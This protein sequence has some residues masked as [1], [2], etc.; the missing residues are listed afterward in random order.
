MV[1]AVASDQ[2]VQEKC[3]KQLAQT[4]S[5]KLKYLSYHPVTG[6]YTA[7]NATRSID[8]LDIRSVA[9]RFLIL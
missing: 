5:R 3:T 4:V 2:V 8:Q 6:Q 9:N 7:E 1:E